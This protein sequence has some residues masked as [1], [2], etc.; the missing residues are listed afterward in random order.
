M[1]KSKLK[2]LIGKKVKLLPFE[3]EPEG[4]G[5]LLSVD[6]STALVC[7]EKKYRIDKFD[8]GLRELE[9]NQLEEIN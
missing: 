7:L 8:D 2:L 6:R 9:F 4:Y 5:E 3:D 1:K